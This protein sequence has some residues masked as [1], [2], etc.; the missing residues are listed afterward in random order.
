MCV[1]LFLLWLPWA[2]Q[3]A[4]F[5]YRMVVDSY[6]FS[7]RTV[8]EVADRACQEETSNQPVIRF[9]YGQRTI[10]FSNKDDVAYILSNPKVNKNY[11]TR[12]ATNFGLNM[13]GMY[14]S[15]LIWNNDLGSW[16]SVRRCF[17]HTLSTS[18]LN[19]L[20]SFVQDQFP[21][22]LEKMPRDENGGTIDML[23]AL[24]WMTLNI[25]LDMMLGL[26]V[27]DEWNKAQ[28]ILEAIVAFFKAWEFFLVRPYIVSVLRPGY[29]K[30]AMAR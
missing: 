13:L 24:R 14:K 6:L 30:H 27:V 7:F 9:P 26:P 10:V 3:I 11:R 29:Q 12:F 17:D 1:S 19:R 15:G 23:D 28:G 18:T 25:T 20:Q 22:I 4:W 8:S 21:K 2:H 5:Y 16:Q